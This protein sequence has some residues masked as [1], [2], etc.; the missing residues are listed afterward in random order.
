MN[1]A[2]GILP[3]QLY[4]KI[5]RTSKYYGQGEIGALFPVNIEPCIWE[6]QVVSAF[7]RYRLKDVNLYIVENGKELRIA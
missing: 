1:L 6:Y 2:N 5:K 7:D 4:A 3:Q